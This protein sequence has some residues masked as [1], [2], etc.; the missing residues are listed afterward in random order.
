MH[1][2]V[3][4]RNGETEKDVTEEEK[5]AINE[6]RKGRV[7]GRVKGVAGRKGGKDKQ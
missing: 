6:E 3:S 4:P 7:P 2:A 5:E 1:T